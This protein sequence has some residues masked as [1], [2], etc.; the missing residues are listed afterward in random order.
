MRMLFRTAMLVGL[1]LIV[2]GVGVFGYILFI[3]PTSL[4]DKP[5]TVVAWSQA[6]ADGPRTEV[7]I[8][9]DGYCRLGI[10]FNPSSN[11]ER[12]L[13]GLTHYVL[14]CRA[15]VTNAVG[16][17]AVF[18]F[19][20][21]IHEKS[22]S[23]VFK[24]GDS[25]D[26]QESELVE[27][28]LPAFA[29]RAGDRL[30]ADVKVFPREPD[31]NDKIGDSDVG[32]ASEVQWF[33]LTGDYDPQARLDFRADGPTYGLQAA[34]IGLLLIVGSFLTRRSLSGAKRA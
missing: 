11:Y 25:Q 12:T 2:G 4:S 33:L 27:H 8:D 7:T 6:K 23:V 30:S 28:Q 24:P 20:D 21:R 13:S 14:T 32:T 5:F 15:T 17:G 29:V 31:P 16:G 9:R 1:A 18:Q 3:Y 26:S 19:D 22:P 34:G 10:R